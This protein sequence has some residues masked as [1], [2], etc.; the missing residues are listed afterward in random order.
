[1]ERRH[2]NK[3]HMELARQVQILTDKI[4]Q[5]TKLTEAVIQQV[6]GVSSDLKAFKQEMKPWM[7]AKIGLN[8]LWRWGITIPVIVA[9]LVGM[10]TVLNWLGFHR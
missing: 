7:E 9:T 4:D 1:M 3:E 6:S 10:K 5:N 8:L 2:N